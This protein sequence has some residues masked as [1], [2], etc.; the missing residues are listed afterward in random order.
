MS[1]KSALSMKKLKNDLFLSSFNSISACFCGRETR[2]THRGGRH[3]A[4]PAHTTYLAGRLDEGDVGFHP[5]RPIDVDNVFV[6]L[7]QEDN[8]DKDSI[9]HSEGEDCYI[10]KFL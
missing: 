9:H 3:R 1:T 4:G 5:Q 7:E 6:E 2:H 10:P 8:K